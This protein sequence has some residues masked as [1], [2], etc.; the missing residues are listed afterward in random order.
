MSIR[1]RAIRRASNEGALSP[2]TVAPDIGKQ[3]LPWVSIYVVNIFPPNILGQSIFALSESQR[4]DLC[5]KYPKMWVLDTHSSHKIL[6]RGYV[7]KW[8][9]TSC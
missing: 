4:E 3:A 8:G 7:A 1:T 2:I 6:V 9:T 5:M